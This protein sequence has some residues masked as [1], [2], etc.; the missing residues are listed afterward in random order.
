MILLE[1]NIDF[2]SKFLKKILIEN[3]IL[4]KNLVY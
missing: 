1:T 4:K 3:I 2:L